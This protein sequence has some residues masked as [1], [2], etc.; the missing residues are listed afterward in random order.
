M[1]SS[2]RLFA[3]A[4]LLAPVILFLVVHTAHGATRPTV[5]FTSAP[6][7]VTAARSATL[8]IARSVPHGRVRAQTCRVDRTSWKPCTRTFAVRDLPDGPHTAQVRLVLRSGLTATATAAWRVDTV[9]PSAPPALGGSD[10]WTA[11]PARTMTHGA[12][13]DPAPGSGIASYRSRISTDGGSSW[14]A[15]PA[16]DVTV[17]AEGETLV[18]FAAVDRAGNASPWSSSAVVRLDRSAPGVPV[19]SGAPDG[20]TNATAVQLSIAGSEAVEHQRSTDGGASWDASGSGTQVDVTDEGETLV[21]A[22]ACDQA[23]N[24]SAWSEPAVVRIDRAAPGVPIVS[25]APIGW[26]NAAAV[27]LAITGTDDVEH[28]ESIDDGGT[29]AASQQGTAVEVAAEGETLV[30]G[31]ACDVAGNCSAW[32]QPVA[33]WIDRTAPSAPVGVTG[34]DGGDP[35]CLYQETQQVTF[36]ALPATDPGSGVDHYVWKLNRFNENSLALHG[37]GAVVHLTYTQAMLRIRIRFAAIDAAGNVGPWSDG[38][39]AGANICLVPPV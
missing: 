17:T 2:P 6:A 12:A 25:G 24:C 21:R 30:R 39:Q 11:A 15:G 22:R 20:W 18:Q 9:A 36:A 8:A 29:W 16:D 4:T 33:V 28:Q 32:S 10:D 37:T 7:E 34:G 13:L 27:S 19:V 38:T 5:R 3:L 14:A 31:R 1:I 26:T 35:S 23:G